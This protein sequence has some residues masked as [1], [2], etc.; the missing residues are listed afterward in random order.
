MDDDVM[1]SAASYRSGEAPEPYLANQ[2][3]AD[4]TGKISTRSA[5]GDAQ[6]AD[7]GQAPVSNYRLYCLSGD[8]H[9]GFADWIEAASDDEA[10]DKARELRPDANKCEVW[11]GNRLVAQI[12]SDG[13]LEPVAS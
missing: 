10:I 6:P 1:S 13:R 11:H 12:R 5:E 3:P 7:T 4:E 8:G 2:A 9:I